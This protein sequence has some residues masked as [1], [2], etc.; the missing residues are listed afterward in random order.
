MAELAQLMDQEIPDGRQH[1]QDSYKNLEKVAQYCRENY[2]QATDKRAALE[3]TKNYTTH[4]LASVAYQINS[5]ATNFLKLLDLQQNQLAE[6]ESGVNYLAQTV[7]IHK[8][9]VARREIGVLTTNRSSTRPAGVKNGIIFPEQAEKP[10][11]YQRKPIDYSSL[12]ELGHGVRV[13][14]Q[15]II[16]GSSKPARSPSVSSGSSG[17]A[18]TSHPPTPPMNRGGGTLGRSAG[19]HYRTPAPP[20]APPSVPSQYASSNYT[21]QTTGLPGQSRASQVRG[22]NY[23]QMSVSSVTPAAAP[24]PPPPVGMATPMSHPGAG[25]PQGRLSQLNSQSSIDNLP[26][27]P[28]P[29]AVPGGDVSASPPLP[30]PPQD[31]AQYPSYQEPPLPPPEFI[32][33]QDDMGY[34]QE[35]DPYAATGPNFAQPD[36]IPEYYI[37]KVIAIYDYQAE[38]EDELSFNENS[39]IFVTKKN[40]DGWY[41][42]VMNGVTGLFPGNYVEPCM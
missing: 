11:K 35:E 41:E 33:D 13:Q 15:G 12:D 7:N 31:N 28:T 1:L 19:S 5:L 34:R 38:K 3:E 32:D 39:L 9:K 25:I 18:P 24:A 14:E 29:E 10:T 23:G 37:E 16:K 42:G 20:V 36:W 27:P 26:P 22:S 2:V 17:Q 6:M 21:V 30:P 8:E 4:S 40:D